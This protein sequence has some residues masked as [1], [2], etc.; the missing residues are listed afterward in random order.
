MLEYL[1]KT[2]QELISTP[3]WK[4]GRISGF[5]DL[6]HHSLTHSPTHGDEPFLRSRQLCSHLRTSQ[7]F[8]EPEGSLPCSQQP[9][10][11]PYP[12]LHTTPSSFSKI[13][14]NITHSPMS[15]SSQWAIF[16]CLSRK[17]SICSYLLSHPCYM[18]C[19][20]HPPLLD[21]SN[22]TWRTLQVMKPRLP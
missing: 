15:L 2:Q 13:H 4:H 20:Y 5:S 3:A 22:Y 6:S 19:P 18:P 9:S 11:G 8:M 16:F 14:P 12:E 17:H 7:Q 21:Y 1:P 10:T